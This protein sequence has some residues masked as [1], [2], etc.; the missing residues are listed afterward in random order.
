MEGKPPAPKRPAQ[1]ER[2]ARLAAALRDNLRRRKAQARART[3]PPAVGEA[4]PAV[5]EAPPAV[6]GAAPNPA[7]E[8]G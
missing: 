4:P 2:E 5:D 6:G 3:A 7:E 8:A 1:T